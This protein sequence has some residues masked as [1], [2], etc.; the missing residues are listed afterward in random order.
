MHAPIPEDVASVVNAVEEAL[1]LVG[2]D[3]DVFETDE[4]V[5]GVVAGVLGVALL[6]VAADADLTAIQTVFVNFAHI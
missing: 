4:G 2:D 3:E 1:F 5:D 6:P